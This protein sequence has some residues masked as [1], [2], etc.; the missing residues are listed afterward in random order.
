MQSKKFHPGNPH[1]QVSM[2]RREWL[3]GMAAMAVGGWG[4]VVPGAWAQTTLQ[5][6]PIKLVC[7]Y[8]AGGPVDVVGRYMAG[9]LQRG[10][11]DGTPTFI[12]NIP[13]AGG[14]T[15]TLNV[16]RAPADGHTL[17]A[18]V[19]AAMLTTQLLNR[20]AGY[21]AQ[22]QF[23][24]LWGLASL[25]TVILV[26]VQSPYRSARA[27]VE[28]ARAQPG[29]LT[30][31][32]AGMGSTPHI[33]TEMFTHAVGARM[34]HVPYNSSA[35]AITDLMGGHIDCFLASIASSTGLINEGRVRGLAV[36]RPDRIEEIAEVPTLQETGLTDWMLPPAIFA[37]YARHEVPDALRTQ[38]AEALQRGLEA[39]RESVPRL[40]KLGLTG[41]IAGA[42]LV[43]TVRR[44]A[45]LLRKTIADAKIPVEG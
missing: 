35:A 13:G 38:I 42:E 1:S 27:L 45:D 18:Q 4:G 36:L 16:L 24:P 40:R 8:G 9:C 29:K 14:I 19:T 22:K 17:L 5:S 6:K 39:D 12:E 34:T 31:G 3:A 44:E 2:P 37:L 33:N 25:G 28:A 15:G 23:V 11:N 30:Y 20:R 21:D 32:S 10:L 43:D 41:A 26:N 7:P